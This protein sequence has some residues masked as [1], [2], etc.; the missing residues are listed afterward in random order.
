MHPSWYGDSSGKQSSNGYFIEESVHVQKILSDGNQETVSL[1]NAPEVQEQI[2]R[3]GVKLQKRELETGKAEP[4]GNAGLK[5]AEFTITTLNANPVLVNGKMYTENQ[6]VMA[7]VTDEKGVASTE[8]DT[9]P[10]GHYRIDETQAPQG[11]LNEGRISVEFDI[12][13]NG[14]IVDLTSEELAISN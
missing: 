13:T 6:V 14:E 9:L 1:Y 10:F 7:L 3:G 8:K 12:T 4:Q 11:Y 5:D 2:Y